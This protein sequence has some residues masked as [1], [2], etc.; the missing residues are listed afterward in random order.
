MYPKCQALQL[1]LNWNTSEWVAFVGLRKFFRFIDKKLCS[2]YMMLRTYYEL[3]YCS[4]CKYELSTDT[5]ELFL[6]III[7]YKKCLSPSTDHR[8]RGG[9]SEKLFCWVGCHVYMSPRS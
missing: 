3:F 8:Q 5:G 9:E 2:L 7:Y 6:I 4:F 1:N